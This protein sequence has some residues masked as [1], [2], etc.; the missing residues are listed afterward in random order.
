MIF[1][2]RKMRMF[3]Y[4][5]KNKLDEMQEQK[6]LHIERNGCWFAFWALLAAMIIQLVISPESA[7]EKLAG[8]WIVFMCL[9]VYVGFSCV[10]N[11]IWDRRLEANPKTNARVSIIAGVVVGLIFGVVNYMQYG[12]LGTAIWIAVLNV[13]F[14]GIICFATLSLVMVVYKKRLNKMEMEEE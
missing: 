12:Y 2:G 8:E 7:L 6:L 9:A 13:F 10:K 11:G 5:K 4:D 1:F 3:N 14:V